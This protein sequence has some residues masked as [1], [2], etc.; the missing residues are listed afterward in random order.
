LKSAKVRFLTNRRPPL[1][2][3]ASQRG[4]P[5]FARLANGGVITEYCSAPIVGLDKLDVT[6]AE[7]LG[8]FVKRD[9]GRIPPATLKAAEILLA[10]AGTR[11]DL[12]LGQALLP[13]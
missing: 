9:D 4:S 2:N 10:K 7:S 11:F 3:A 1:R 8:E 13:T 5:G 12:F 6:N